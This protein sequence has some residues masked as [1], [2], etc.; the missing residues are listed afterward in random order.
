MWF[1]L[2]F[3]IIDPFSD[4]WFFLQ[5]QVLDS[6]CAQLSL[7]HF[8]QWHKVEKYWVWSLQ[9]SLG[10][11]SADTK[12]ACVVPSQVSEQH[13]VA[14]VL[15]KHKD[16]WGSP[17]YYLWGIRNFHNSFVK[18]Q[19]KKVLVDLELTAGLSVCCVFP[20]TD[21]PHGWRLFLGS[22]LQGSLCSSAVESAQG[23]GTIHNIGNF[24]H[25]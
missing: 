24:T 10:E 25:F 21:N 16:L 7:V 8:P 23:H 13:W 20:R 5:V 15:P 2:K 18:D 4:F 11:T 6:S 17:H 3:S 1:Q 19:Y 12:P 9:Q 14:G 22:F